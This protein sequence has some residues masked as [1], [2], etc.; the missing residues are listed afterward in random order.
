MCITKLSSI[1]KIIYPITQFDC[2]DDIINWHEFQI[3]NQTV[4]KFYIAFKNK[5][6]SWEI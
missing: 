1:Y 6:K 3:G 5:I 2:V 4:L